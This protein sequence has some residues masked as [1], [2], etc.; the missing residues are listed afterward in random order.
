MYITFPQFEAFPNELKED[1]Q[2]YGNFG[3]QFKA[4]GLTFLVL[5]LVVS[6]IVHYMASS[7]LKEYIYEFW[8][9][10]G[11]FTLIYLNQLTQKS[12]YLVFQKDRFYCFPPESV[13]FDKTNSTIFLFKDF[14]FKSKTIYS[15]LNELIRN[16]Y[17]YN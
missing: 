10:K 6:N 1:F 13:M 7:G 5:P 4:C 9:E 8:F 14:K 2:K 16:T 3:L 17:D 12:L 15:K 11:Y